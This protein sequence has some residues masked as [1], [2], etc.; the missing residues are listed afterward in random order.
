MNK[1]IKKAADTAAEIAKAHPETRTQYLNGIANAQKAQQEAARAKEE[2]TTEAAFNKACDD[3]T[4]AREKEAFFTRQLERL[5]NTPRMEEAEYYKHVDAVKATVE[6]AAMDFRR[7]AEKAI[8]D[9]AAA[10]EAYL[11][12]TKDADEALTALDTAAN[13]L[14]TK[15]KYRYIL[16][17]GME[18]QPI[19]DRTEGTRHAIRYN[20]N[21]KA[22]DLIAKD[23][24]AWNEKT[25]AAWKAADSAGK[26][27]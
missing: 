9:L 12:I 27:Y 5:D 21:G 10:K 25:R 17:Q 24:E 19:E 8:D 20:K 16:R 11:E 3:E 4:H 2:A 6:K 15:F 1:E 13:V 18:P 23:G 26:E 22:Y 7:I 14:Q